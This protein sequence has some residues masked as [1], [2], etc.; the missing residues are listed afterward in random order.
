META[1]LLQFL[2]PHTDAAM[3]QTDTDF[4]QSPF[5]VSNFHVYVVQSEL[6]VSTK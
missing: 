2:S 4:S 3:I 6:T 5:P 1:C